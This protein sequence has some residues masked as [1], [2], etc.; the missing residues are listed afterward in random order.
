MVPLSE[1][2]PRL[3]NRDWIVEADG[4]L[5]RATQLGPPTAR[6]LQAQLQRV[7]CARQSL[8]EPAPWA[9][10]LRIYDRLT[11]LRD[12][13]FVRINRAVAVAEV[14][15]GQAA[16]REIERLDC[17]TL[18]GFAPYHA[19][20]AD[21]LARVGR[22]S[23][24]RGAYETVLSLGVPPAEERWIRRRLTMLDSGG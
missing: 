19:V 18:A 15:G 10:I 23:D 24:A 13:P 12:D 17:D 2:D 9:E 5:A 11:A 20:R 8:A 1:Q 6:L 22:H 3:W 7:W 14:C 21:L 4:L 16:L